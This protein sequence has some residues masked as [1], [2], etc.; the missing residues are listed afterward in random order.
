MFLARVFITLKP[1]VND[2]QGQTILGGLRTLR[3]MEKFVASGEIDLVS[4]SRPFIREPDLIRRFARSDASASSCI[5]CNKCFNPR[6]IACAELKKQ[7]N[8]G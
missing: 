4:M 1:T 3:V 8:Q 5:S 7:K 6:G 2:P